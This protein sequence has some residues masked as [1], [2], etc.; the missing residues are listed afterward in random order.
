MEHYKYKL[1]RLSSSDKENKSDTNSN[2]TIDLSKL[3]SQEL[4]KCI[5]ISLVESSFVNCFYNVRTGVNNTLSILQTGQTRQDI[6]LPEGFYTG[7]LLIQKLKTEIDNVLV[8]DSVSI[9]FDQF[10]QKLIF[11]LTTGTLIIYNDN[12][13]TLAS[14]LGFISTTIPKQT[15]K[16]DYVVKLNGLEQAY[17]HVDNVCD[18]SLIDKKHGSTHA[19]LKVI[20]MNSEYLGTQF[21]E[22]HT[23]DRVIF[24]KPKSLNRIWKI[25]LTNSRNEDLDLQN[26][27]LKLIIAIFH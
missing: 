5:G 17:I 1:L 7:N 14:T 6:I 8:G 4:E 13:S 15:N 25:R 26:Y 22:S 2:F 9:T 11:T 10:D 19:V 23:S 3:G 21:Y 16:A 18:D 27:T 20:N 12:I 24:Q